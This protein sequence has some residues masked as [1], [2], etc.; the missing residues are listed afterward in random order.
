MLTRF[1]RCHRFLH[2][3]LPYRYIHKMHHTVHVPYACA[4]FYLHPIEALLL[5][6]G[7]AFV[8]AVLFPGMRFWTV[9]LIQLLLPVRATH[10]HLGFQ[11]PWDVDT[12]LTEKTTHHGIHH[13]PKGHKFNYA[14]PFFTFT[15]RLFGTKYPGDEAMKA[16]RAKKAE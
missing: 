1:I 9:V 2:L 15:D 12:Y 5:D 6:H 3:P 11:F 8:A 4:A 14:T 13:L 16:I 7:A 10:E